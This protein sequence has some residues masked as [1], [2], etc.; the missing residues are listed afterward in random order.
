MTGSSAKTID[1]SVPSVVA[2]NRADPDKPIRILREEISE[3]TLKDLVMNSLI[4]TVVC[5]SHIFLYLFL[6]L[7]LL[8]YCS[9]LS[10]ILL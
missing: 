7:L 10:R 3:S 2:Y 6:L 9:Y 8:L 1:V 4:V 5:T